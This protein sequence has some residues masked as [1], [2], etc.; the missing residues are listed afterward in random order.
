M[1]RALREGSEMR[2]L[3]R[4]C[5][6]KIADLPAP[7]PFSIPALVAAMEAASGRGIRLVAVDAPEVD[8]R[9][10]CGLRIRG[11]DSTV[12]L[13]RPRSTPHQT[14]HVILHELSHEWLDHG[15]GIP[16]DEAM[17]SM[18][19]SVQSEVAE[20]FRPG[21]VVQ[22]R[23]RYGSVDEREA[24]LSAYLIKRRI[25]R[26]AVSGHDL[27]SRLESSLSHPLAPARRPRRGEAV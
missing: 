17:R 9:T 23:T 7:D 14:E 13:Y 8:L 27:V 6:R 4:D 24:E 10:A 16:L 25:H 18:P 3:L 12:V 2:K 20:V 21:V 11:A 1:L 22:A 15:T 19:A 5:A 26:A